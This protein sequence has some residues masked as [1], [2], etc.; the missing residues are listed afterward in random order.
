M[1]AGGDGGGQMLRTEPWRR[2]QDHHVDVGF[3]DLLVGVEAGVAA[4]RRDLVLR[5]ERR[6]GS[7]GLR[8]LGLRFLEPIGDEIAHRDQLHAFRS[9][10]TV[11]RGF[12]SKIFALS[13]QQRVAHRRGARP[14]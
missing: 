10:Q 3:Q 8:Q 7:G 4:L 11:A 2:R 6:I 13:F 5:G 14:P 12:V 9:A 1:F